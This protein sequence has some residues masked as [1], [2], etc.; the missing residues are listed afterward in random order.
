MARNTKQTRWRVL[1]ASAQTTP[2]AAPSTTQSVPIP[3]ST[4]QAGIYTFTN[5]LPPTRTGANAAPSK[6]SVVKGLQRAPAL[7]TPKPGLTLNTNG[8]RPASPT[9]IGSNRTPLGAINNNGRAK[10]SITKS[11]KQKSIDA[12]AEWEGN[13]RGTVRGREGTSGPV[14]STS[15]PETRSEEADGEGEM[16]K[17][18]SKTQH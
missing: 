10:R 5:N 8:K 15:T 13:Q 12:D 1:T 4:P 16:S 9:K 14:E 17:G 7:P 18:S 2:S 6:A 11:L 3:S